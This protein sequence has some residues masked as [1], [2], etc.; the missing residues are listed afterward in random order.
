MNKTTKA[1]LKKIIK[2]AKDLQQTIA[3]E[4]K[5]SSRVDMLNFHINEVVRIELVILEEQYGYDEECGEDGENNNILTNDSSNVKHGNE[6]K[7]QETIK[8]NGKLEIEVHTDEDSDDNLIINNP[9]YGG[10]DTNVDIVA[11][12]NKTKIKQKG[13]TINTNN[14]A[15]DFGQPRNIG[16]L[17]GN[18]SRHPLLANQQQTYRVH[19]TVPP[20]I[21]TSPHLTLC[22]TH[23]QTTPTRPTTEK[24]NNHNDHSINAFNSGER[25]R[26]SSN[27]YEPPPKKKPRMVSITAPKTFEKTYKSQNILRKTNEGIGGGRVRNVFENVSRTSK[28]R[29]H[30]GTLQTNH[31]SHP[32]LRRQSNNGGNN[33]TNMKIGRIMSH[34]FDNNNSTYSNNNN[35]NN[36]NGYT[37]DVVP[38]Q[39]EENAEVIESHESNKVP[40]P[41]PPRQQLQQQ[42]QL[43]LQQ[44]DGNSKTI[45]NSLQ[46]SSVVPRAS[47]HVGGGGVR[48][49][50]VS[51]G[52]NGFM[53]YI[54]SSDDQ[55]ENDDSDDSLYESGESSEDDDDDED[56]NDDNQDD[57]KTTSDGC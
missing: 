9:R 53:M 15:R 43:Q 32:S 13:N 34:V 55:D 14:A 40:P 4:F 7:G 47:T 20:R 2:I 46:E 22:Q 12:N 57:R 16:I 33:V 49:R 30:N 1:R 38:C 31:L 5:D 39:R 41:P 3:E 8:N 11:N 28:A 37:N 21:R 18:R 29:P 24:N 42:L 10:D 36:N 50:Y 19:T 25:E 56:D 17:N 44:N 52:I 48:W 6:E 23:S 26:E 45:R 54:S 27:I 51:G 35:N